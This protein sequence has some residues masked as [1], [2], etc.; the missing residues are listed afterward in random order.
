MDKF[1]N[2]YIGFVKAPSTNHLSTPAFLFLG[3]WLAEWLVFF[4]ASKL[5]PGLLAIDE[6]SA[7]AF[8]TWLI[9]LFAVMIVISFLLNKK[10]SAAGVSILLLVILLPVLFFI[11]LTLL[12]MKATMAANTI[13]NGVSQKIAGA[14]YTYSSD[15]NRVPF[16]CDEYEDIA[17]T[18]VEKLEKT[19]NEIADCRFMRDQKCSGLSVFL[20]CKRPQTEGV[21]AADRSVFYT[22]E[23]ANRTPS[24]F[25]AS[26]CVA[27][28]H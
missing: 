25:E 20:E 16:R 6:T 10:F 24:G 13:E 11:D 14:Y 1:S 3:C 23:Y 19:C 9:K 22:D 18:A 28:T 21:F 26:Q 17:L 7:F 5:A 4:A 27:K 8:L 2:R 15:A 12:P